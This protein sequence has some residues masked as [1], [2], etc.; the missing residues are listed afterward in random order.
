MSCSVGPGE[1]KTHPGPI[2][3]DIEMIRSSGLTSMNARLLSVSVLM[4]TASL[5]VL[6]GCGGNGP[7]PVPV[8]GTVTLNNQPLEG[9]SV[10]FTPASG[11]NEGLTG[12]DATGPEGNYKLRNRNTFGVS[13]GKYTVLITKELNSGTSTKNSQD[14]VM[15]DESGQSIGEDTYMAQLAVES[16]T[17]AGA[18]APAAKT[19]K[20]EQSFEQEVPAGGGAFDFDVK[21]TAEDA[22]AL[23][24]K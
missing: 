5:P 6:E 15:V 4:L 1:G 19:I 20:V 12:I 23:R 21:A 7:K 13:P 2:V 16:A 14:Y 8:T 10:I 17:E 3:P 22:K 11:N 24:G 18:G 9:A